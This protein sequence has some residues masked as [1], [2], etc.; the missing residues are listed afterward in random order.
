MTRPAL[1]PAALAAATLLALSQAGLA[2]APGPAALAAPDQVAAERAPSASRIEIIEVTSPGG[3]MAWLYEDHTIPVVTL[4]ASF[5]GGAALDPADKAGATSL[6]ASLLSEGAGDL[7][8]TAFAAE[9]ESLA[10]SLGFSAGAD[11]VSISA[12]T[13]VENA[14]ATFDLLRLALVEPRFEEDSLARARARQMATLR[15]DATDPNRIASRS[16]WARAFPDH[17]YALPSDGTIETVE[18]LDRDDVSAAHARALARNNLLVAVV[19]AMDADTLAP[20]LDAVFG[21]MPEASAERPHPAEAALAGSVEVI[22]LAIPQSVVA[23]GH[24]GIPRDDPDFIPAF[25]L[26]HVLGGGG[27]GSRLTAEVRE[28]RGLTYGI[29]T[30]LAPNDLGWLYMGSFS[31]ANDRVAEA[32]ELVRAEW[33]RTAAEGITADELERAKQFLT[34]AYALRFDGNARIASQLLGLQI[35]GLGPDYVNERNALVEAV[36]LEDIRRVAGR[37]LDPDDLSFVIVGQPQGVEATE[38]AV[39]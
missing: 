30:Y 2:G 34:G 14:D 32:I 19:G 12:T 6:M 4:E 28:R 8:A 17:P 29:Y 36:T 1:L 16:F 13:L 11:G 7:D 35:A 18:A 9:L 23:F 26:D 31:S 24:A 39:R 5:R 3:I 38:A 27:F 33:A 20:L 21:D 25:V 22:E 37:L 15:A 10:S